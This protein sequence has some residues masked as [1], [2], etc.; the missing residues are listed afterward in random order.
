MMARFGACTSV[1]A[2][3]KIYMTSTLTILLHPS[4]SPFSSCTAIETA[5]CPSPMATELHKPIQMPHSS[6]YMALT[7]AFMVFPSGSPFNSSASFY[8]VKSKVYNTHKQKSDAPQMETSLFY[9][10]SVTYAPIL[11]LAI[12]SSETQ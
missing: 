1:D 12:S 3:R 6:C 8:K 7:T 9:F 4:R 11:F 2:M 10:H 5:S